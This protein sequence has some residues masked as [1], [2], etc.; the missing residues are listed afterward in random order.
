M[1]RV[2][3]LKGGQQPKPQPPSRQQHETSTIAKVSDD[4]ILR[5]VFGKP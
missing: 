1:F 2:V 5:R 3:A 4:E